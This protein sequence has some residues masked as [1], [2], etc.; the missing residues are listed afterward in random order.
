MRRQ[1][2]GT[3]GTARQAHGLT[4]QLT[5]EG[6]DGGVEGSPEQNA[7]EQGRGPFDGA[8]RRRV[9]A[10][11]I[12]RAEEERVEEGGM[13][14]VGLGEDVER[15]AGPGLR[16]DDEPARQEREERPGGGGHRSSE[17]R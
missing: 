11:T 4:C 15:A 1:P 16:G 14:S 7:P 13:V 8:E 10:R 2:V 17:G 9:L 5:E 3:S 6:A 12:A